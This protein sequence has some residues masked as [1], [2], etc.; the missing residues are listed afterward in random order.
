[1]NEQKKIVVI[2]K[3]RQKAIEHIRSLGYLPAF[4]WLFDNIK[5]AEYM[6]KRYEVVLINL[7]EKCQKESQL[8][9]QSKRKTGTKTKI[10]S[11]HLD[12]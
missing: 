7:E 4:T 5:K 9:S 2:C 10:T 12:F 11:N 3:D 8:K 6:I 1:M